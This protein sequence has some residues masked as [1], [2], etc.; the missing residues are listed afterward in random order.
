MSSRAPAHN[1]SPRPVQVEGVM[2]FWRPPL[3]KLTAWW[4]YN[5]KNQSNYRPGHAS[6]KMRLPEF[7]DI[8]HVKVVRLSALRSGR[9]YHQEIFLV[10][11]SLR[12][13][14][15][16]RAMVRP[17]GLCQWKIPE[18]AIGNLIVVAE[19]HTTSRIGVVIFMWDLGSNC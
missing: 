8:R 18:T 16:P 3:A 13:W 11:I 10:H 5:D 6:R 14:V 9:L 17:E 4:N 2:I 12:G 7:L 19:Y 1:W 15:D